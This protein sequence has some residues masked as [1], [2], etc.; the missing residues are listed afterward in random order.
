[1][2]INIRENIF[3]IPGGANIIAD[4]I[5]QKQKFPTLGIRL[6]NGCTWGIINLDGTGEG[7]VALLADV[8]DLLPIDPSCCHR[9]MFIGNRDATPNG[10]N[11]TPQKQFIKISAQ[12][13]QEII[14]SF[15]ISPAKSLGAL[16]LSNIGMVLSTLLGLLSQ[17]DGGLLIH[18]ALV[19]RNGNGILMA[20][21]SKVGKTTASSRLPHSWHSLCDDM[22]LIVRDDLGGYWVHPW[23]TWSR[24][25]RNGSGDRWKVERAIPLKGIFVLEQGEDGARALGCGQAACLLLECTKQATNYLIEGLNLSE[26]EVSA[27]NLQRFENVCAL[28][29]AIP[30]YL[31]RLS[32]NGSFWI[33]MEIALNGEAKEISNSL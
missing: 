29:K 25:R 7:I 2:M 20:G 17:R 23:P 19:E 11:N 6:G 9:L 3:K 27:Y 22:A 5:A 12:S 13:F 30:S 28:A 4:T 10:I 1:M 26:E 18:G 24:F 15:N 8:M 16:A 21:R 31:L 32:L 33:E 14:V